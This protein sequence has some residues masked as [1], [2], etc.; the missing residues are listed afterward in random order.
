LGRGSTGH[1]GKQRETAA[2]GIELGAVVEQLQ[3]IDDGGESDAGD[4][5]EGATRLVER[6]EGTVL[7]TGVVALRGLDAAIGPGVQRHQQGPHGRSV[8]VRIRRTLTDSRGARKDVRRI[9]PAVLKAREEI[10]PDVVREQDGIPEAVGRVET[11]LHL[12]ELVAR[13]ALEDQWVDSRTLVQAIVDPRDRVGRHG[14]RERRE[15]RGQEIVA[16]VLPRVGVRVGELHVGEE[17]VG[18]R[19]VDPQPVED[20]LVG[21]VFIEAQVEELPLVHPRR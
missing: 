17:P 12:P 6:D 9:V 16:I 18:A 3:L 13:V 10:E 11:C 8:V 21:L 7:D 14:M 5:G 4:L 19:L 2:L 15:A 20:L 1:R